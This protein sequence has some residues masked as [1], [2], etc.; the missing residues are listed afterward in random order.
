MKQVFYKFGALA[1]LFVGAGVYSQEV[2]RVGIN[3]T[4]PKSILDI[5][6][7]KGK[8]GP[9]GILI[10]RL[11]ADEVKTMTDDNQVG[12][13]QN[14][15]L[16]YITDLFSDSKNKI[17]KYE[18][19]DKVGYYYWD[20]KEEKWKRIS[21][22]SLL[23][24]NGLTKKN[25]TIKLGGRLIENTQLD[26]NQKDL[27]LENGR[28]YASGGGFIIDN[29]TRKDGYNHWAGLDIFQYREA[30]ED[31]GHANVNLIG[32]QINKRGEKID[33][34]KVD[35]VPAGRILGG[36][37][38]FD[39]KSFSKANPAYSGASIEFYSAE[40]FTETA[41]GTGVNFNVIPK[42]QIASKIA[43]TIT[44]EGRVGIGTKTPNSA[45][46]IED[47]SWAPLVVNST[48]PDGGGIAIHPNDYSKRVELSVT[49][50]GNFRIFANRDNRFYINGATGNTG[51]GTVKPDEK[52]HIKDGHIKIED[53]TQQE[54]RVLTSDANG[55][56]T[57]QALSI[58]NK[59]TQ[60]YFS[61]QMNIPTGYRLGAEFAKEKL[62][63]VSTPFDEIG[64]SYTHESIHLKAGKYIFYVNHDIEGAE[65]CQINVKKSN[66]RYIYDTYYGEW[67][68][69]SFPVYLDKDDD[70][71]FYIRCF[72]DDSFV[73][74]GDATNLP[75]PSPRYYMK[76]IE[77]KNATINNK[78]TIL[79][80]N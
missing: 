56:G 50:D 13:D 62:S 53:G 8:K 67:L 40:Q 10:P 45:L 55:V 64:L 31:K 68:N 25:N 65:Y 39:A 77:Y 74:K 33:F 20:N 29:N 30:G 38:G 72:A 60:V 61:G 12:E 76:S 58:G 52:L 79:K 44:D 7:E 19:I 43:M 36:V 66:G 28:M 48:N 15:L 71:S 1:M 22:E 18:L 27:A 32:G 21:D 59:M 46:T 34:S 69:T 51:I 2:G 47:K 14:S 23:A 75:N 49:K 5:V 11:S 41:K 24:N 80:L 16:L 37:G 3:T 9:S 78:V 35:Y 6:K 57:W 54:G 17:G 4:E 63:N 70:I 42:G 26:L 73:D